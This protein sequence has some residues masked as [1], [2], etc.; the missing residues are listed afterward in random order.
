[1][2]ALSFSAAACRSAPNSPPP[3]NGGTAERLVES[4]AFDP[5]KIGV[6]CAEGQ[7]ACAPPTL[8][9]THYGYAGPSGPAFASCEIPCAGQK[10]CP[11]GTKCIIIGD[12][13]ERALTN[14]EVCRPYGPAERPVLR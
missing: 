12:A 3:S 8:C 1:M 10:P 6:N 14:P 9:V 5:S 7:P 11:G 13:P 2:L 4:P